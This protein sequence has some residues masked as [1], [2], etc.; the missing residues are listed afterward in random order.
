MNT[1]GDLLDAVLVPRIARAIEAT[2]HADPCTAHA[3]HDEYGEGAT[4]AYENAGFC[5]DCMAR[6]HEAFWLV[7]GEK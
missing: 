7:M 3:R 5:D 4:D 2:R 1:L 6:V